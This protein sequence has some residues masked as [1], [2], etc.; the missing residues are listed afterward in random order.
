[1]IKPVPGYEPRGI[2]LA[3]DSGISANIVDGQINFRTSDGASIDV[4]NRGF[5]SISRPESLRLD[6]P[7]KK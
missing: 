5:A 2:T 1:M 6:T 7:R 4:D 3:F